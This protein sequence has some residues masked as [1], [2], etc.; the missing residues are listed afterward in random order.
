[1]INPN[2]LQQ[3]IAFLEQ[4]D[5]L[6]NFDSSIPPITAY[7]IIRMIEFATSQKQW[8]IFGH[9]AKSYAQE[10]REAILL[11]YPESEPF[12]RP[13]ICNSPPSFN[14]EPAPLDRN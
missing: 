6:N 8:D 7:A 1:M 14:Y 2:D 11:D 10:L 3:R 4:L 5:S 12:L 13:I 9:L